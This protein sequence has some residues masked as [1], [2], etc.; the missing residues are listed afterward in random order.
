MTK[1]ISAL[2]LACLLLQT[3]CV[4]YSSRTI[5]KFENDE[6]NSPKCTSAVISKK[7]S[8]G[9]E[10]G[11]IYSLPK[12]LLELTISRIQVTEKTV[13]KEI[14]GLEKKS[15]ELGSRKNV[16]EVSVKDYDAQYEV[17]LGDDTNTEQNA[18]AKQKIALERELAKLKLSVVKKQ[19]GDVSRLL[20]NKRQLLTAI[21]AG[22][23]S[24][25]IMDSFA[26]KQL[27]PFPSN[28]YKFSGKFAES[29]VSTDN[30]DLKTTPSG[31]L[32]GSNYTSEGN[33]DEIVVAAARLVGA[34]TKS[35]V[36]SF[37]QG[38]VTQS[39]GDYCNALPGTYKF[40]FDPS[41][42]NWVEGLQERVNTQKLCYEIYSNQSAKSDTTEQA[43]T[44]NYTTDK[45]VTDSGIPEDGI[46]YDGLV[47]PRMALLPVH[48][49]NSANKTV[50]TLYAEVADYNV[51]GILPFPSAVFAK[52]EVNYEFT[53]GF[54]T[55]YNINLGNG[56]VGALSMIP[57]ALKALIS[58]PAEILQLKVN[59]SNQAA[60]Y[61]NAKAEVYKARLAY[62]HYQNNPEETLE[63]ILQGGDESTPEE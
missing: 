55:R 12:Y 50:G 60:A 16:L 59:Y 23:V 56:V 14:E 44:E 36:K 17:D 6:K 26:I 18:A 63:D 15:T 13:K 53:N 9:T 35:A 30:F 2:L 24:D 22:Y 52:N 11:L 47:Y 48:L 19:L 31:L 41:D 58:V 37:V 49:S 45:T 34:V 61:E 4:T 33:L 38:E 51:L 8:N 42:R 46:V 7:V 40:S 57:E 43:N 10:T 29:Q 3:G 28:K 21:Q 27:G 39:E 5:C 62:E 54:L 20:K 25:K 32:S 1:S